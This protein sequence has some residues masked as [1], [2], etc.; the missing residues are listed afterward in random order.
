MKLVFFLDSHFCKIKGH[1]L[2]VLYQGFE[3]ES[4][5]LC[6]CEQTGVMGTIFGFTGRLDG[7]NRLISWSFLF[8]FFRFKHSFKCNA[9]F[10]YG[11]EI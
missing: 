4:D 1:Y 6:L 7:G 10:S 3:K 8:P 9:S 11:I 5:I 2:S